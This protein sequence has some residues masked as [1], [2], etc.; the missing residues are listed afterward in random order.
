MANFYNEGATQLASNGATN[1]VTGDIRAL[2]V[3]ALYVFNP[4]NTF[5][6]DLTNELTNPGYARVVIGTKAGPTKDNPNDRAYFTFGNVTFTSLGAGSTPTAMI[7]FRHTGSDAT[8]PL[9]TYHVLTAPPA[10]N[11][12]NY[13]I[14]AGALTTGALRLNTT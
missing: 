8:A 2:L 9:L 13:T 7:L 5:V 6:S 1:F 3:S 14:N 4:D 10:P 12:A 11:G